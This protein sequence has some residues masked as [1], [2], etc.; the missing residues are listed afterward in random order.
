MYNAN[1]VIPMNMVNY[2]RQN[3]TLRMN[4]SNPVDAGYEAYIKDNY[5]GATQTISFSSPT[6]YVFTVNSS[7][8]GSKATDR[9]NILFLPSSALPV[10]GL[11]LNGAAEGKQVKLQFTALNERDMSGYEIE[12]SA[13]GRSYTKIGDQLA[14]NGIAS[15]RSY[16]FIH[17]QPI[18]G[19][20]Y[21]RVKGMSLNG[22]VQYSNVKVIR[23]GNGLPT[24]T[25]A[26][27]PS[28]NDKVKLKVSQLLK[29]NYTVTVTDALG[30]VFSKKE[31][32]Y[33]GVSGMMELKFPT[34]AKGGSYYVKVDGEGVSFIE[35]FIIR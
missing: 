20:N 35:A 14:V 11:E 25:V 10:S 31:L 19:N 32:V 34:L 23:L 24:V 2:V 6:D 5:T 29:G 4:W 1:T 16:A 17:N 3:Y 33:D 13:D 22:Q 9:F 18:E 30:R 8:A 21:Y 28:G 7:I 27:N 12:H 26:P 15:A